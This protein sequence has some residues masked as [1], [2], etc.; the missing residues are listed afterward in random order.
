MELCI[1]SSKLMYTGEGGVV[2]KAKTGGSL[3]PVFLDKTLFRISK[4][5]QSG[6]IC[7]QGS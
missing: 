3:C 6:R 2:T 1:Q 7:I 4:F 5:L